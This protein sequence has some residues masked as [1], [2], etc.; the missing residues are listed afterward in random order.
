MRAKL[1]QIEKSAGRL[2][3]NLNVKAAAD[4]YDGP[5]SNELLVA[6]AWTPSDD[7]NAVI[8]A[9]RRIGRLIEILEA[10]EA[11]KD[12]ESWASFSAGE[13]VKA[14]KLM[15]PKGHQGN[16]AVNNWIAMMMAAYREI[17]GCEP[18][19]SVGGF[20]Q[21]N[22]GIASGPFIR[23]LMTAGKPIGIEYGEEAWRSRVR[24]IQKQAENRGLPESKKAKTN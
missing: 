12:L 10:I 21:P 11:A 4:A 1:Q 23:F 24:T 3:K 19:T 17:T 16:L 18:A 15:V 9:T 20:G 7:E 2:L 5:G 6:L 8:T 14:G 13:V 22:E